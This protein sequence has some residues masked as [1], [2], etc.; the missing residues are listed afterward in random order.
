MSL[1]SFVA[2][3]FFDFAYAIAYRPVTQGKDGGFPKGGNEPFRL[4]KPTLNHWYADPLFAVIDGKEYLFM[5]V[6][7][8]KKNKGLIGVSEFTEK[9]V[10]TTP[11]IILEEDFH[12]SFPIIFKYGEDY[13]LMPECSASQA[14]RFYKLNPLTLEVSLLRAI[15]TQ[16]RLVDTVL[17][18]L[19]DRFLTLLSC[20]ENVENP[21]QT[22]LI[23]YSLPD[24]LTGEL[25]E[26][27]LPEEYNS[28]SYLLRNG[29]PV[30]REGN[31]IIRILQES[32]ET[33]YGHNL[34][35]REVIFSKK[36]AADLA[37]VTAGD[38]AGDPARVSGKNCPDDFCSYAETDLYKLFLEDLNLSLPATWRK[39]GT[40]TYSL[41]SAHETVDISFNRFHLGNMSY[42]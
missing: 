23:M 41:G 37:K 20:R 40:H 11:R 12:L 13:I 14:L 25:T 33:E 2:K 4:L 17:F 38:P 8:R 18:D 27:P 42:K 32:T 15:P 26:I 10:L 30:Y 22:G 19:N 24:L 36:N 35:F 9:G 7:D 5:E 3:T 29:G 39:Q 1:K 31:K 21:R 16:D 28:P 34:I 6:F